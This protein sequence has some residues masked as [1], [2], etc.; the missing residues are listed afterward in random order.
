MMMM[1]R[2]GAAAVTEE[3]ADRS[4]LKS[5]WPPGRPKE[6]ED[7]TRP[8]VA[9]EVE[10]EVPVNQ[11]S[12]LPDVD[13]IGARTLDGHQLDLA[14][15]VV[16]PVQNPRTATR[17]VRLRIDTP[18]AD[19][20]FAN[21]AIVAVQIPTTGPSPMTIVPKD[22][23]IPVADG[24]IV[25]LAVEGRAKRQPIKLGAAVTS[26]FIVQS[27]LSAGAVV[28]TRGNEQLSDGKTIEYE[29]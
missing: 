11:V 7:T 26:G 21:N 2:R 25:Y 1:I 6:A 10:V 20:I 27:G 8:E 13:M 22:A 23:V 5:E 16:L 28:V 14:V 29:G 24:H 18:P 19:V 9:A 3:P 17:T 4:S 12:F 15:R